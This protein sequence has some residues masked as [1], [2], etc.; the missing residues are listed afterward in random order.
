MGI[1]TSTA[2]KDARVLGNDIKR[3]LDGIDPTSLNSKLRGLVKSLTAAQYGMEKCADAANKIANTK[4]PTEDY[5]YVSKELDKAE[6]SLARMIEKQASMERDGD[7]MGRS[8]QTLSAEIERTQKNISGLKDELR[9]METANEAFVSGRTTEAFQKNLKSLNLQNQL[10]AIAIERFKEYAEANGIVINTTQQETEAT[11]QETEA[12]KN[13]QKAEEELDNSRRKRGVSRGPALHRGISRGPA[14]NPIEQGVVRGPAIQGATFLKEGQDVRRLSREEENLDNSVKKTNVDLEQQNKSL[15]NT[16]RGFNNA[17]RAARSF[18]STLL[19]SIGKAIRRVIS[20]LGSISRH[21]HSSHKS[22]RGLG[23]SMKHTFTTFMRY[24]LGIRS[25]FMLVRRLRGYIKE[26]FGVMAQEIPEVNKDISMLGTSFKELKATFGTMLQPLL[27]ALAPILNDL[28]QKVIALMNNIAK[29]FATLTGQNY[30]YQATV[31]NYDYAKSAEEAQKAN[32]GALASFDKLNVIQKDNT[33]NTMALTK[34]T[35]KYKKVKIEPDENNWWVAFGKLLREGWKNINLT[36]AGEWFAEGIA[37]LLDAIP[38]DRIQEKGKN[39]GKLA[40]TFINGITNPDDLKGKSHLAVAIGGFFANLIQL[41]VNSLSSFVHTI[42]WSNLGK[43]IA[44][45]IDTLKTQLRETDAWKTAGEAFGRLFQGLV[46]FG[47]ELVVKGNIFSGLGTDLFTMFSAAL[48]KGLE[49]NPETGNTYLKDFGIMITNALT[50]FLDEV[51]D[52]L[53]KVDKDGKLYDAIN[54][55][56]LG[57][58]LIEI[59]KRMVKVFLKGFKIGLKALVE[60][61][62][63]A[64][65]ISVDADTAEFFAEAIGIGILGSKIAGLVRNITGSGGLLSAFTKKD[66]SLETQ[67]RKVESESAAVGILSGILGLLGLTAGHTSDEIDDLT[68]KVY[69]MGLVA[70]ED[71]DPALV[72]IRDRI[73]DIGDAGQAVCKQVEDDAKASVNDISLTF[74][75][76]VIKLNEVD[77]SAYN[78]VISIS[79][80]VINTLEQMWAGAQLIAHVQY[81]TP[82]GAIDYGHTPTSSEQALIGQKGNATAL[83]TVGVGAGLTSVVKADSLAETLR[84]IVS[85]DKL[86]T[87]SGAPYSQLI[88]N[89]INATSQSNDAIL[90]ANAQDLWN[91]IN[92]VSDEK[93][94]EAL[95]GVFLDAGKSMG[96]N[97]LEE[98]LASPGAYAGTWGLILANSDGWESIVKAA[99]HGDLN[100]L[101][102]PFSQREV[103]AEDFFRAF[104]KTSSW[105]NLLMGGSYSSLSLPVIGGAFAKGVVIPPNKPSLGILGDQTNGTNVE[106]P[107]STIKQAVAEVLSSIQIKNTFDVKGDPN[108]IFKVVVDESK[109]YYNQHG[110]S[111]F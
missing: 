27:H 93:I 41:G 26:A 19:N 95:M 50:K 57:I 66:R 3:I 106:T 75:Q 71:A 40:A 107:L 5:A 65:G 29:F 63:G 56:F 73:Y 97:K 69:A 110:Y 99:V 35:V 84:G 76:A 38:W 91:Q 20:G 34:D 61:A 86:S 62:A 103:D 22:S 77:T 55:L 16:S 87:V 12:T 4:I 105:L 83:S 47:L 67:R 68:Q 39:G 6:K 10:A 44:D 51:I 96:Y 31:A 46:E 79:K 14:I 1:D 43:F 52:F 104:K 11:K 48:E 64:L 90:K 37:G 101:K 36:E 21:L 89:S 111:A 102:M 15:G 98:I 60:G 58:D 85:A 109:I 59:A 74:G 78:S 23:D 49:V 25:I 18:A 82:D 100:G 33:K 80:Q 108:A 54:Q 94:Q 70:E 92:V 17:N 42:D 28:I 24:T 30:V 8:Y 9:D 53:D 7:T 13:L 32:E 45:S 88:A 81:K 2:L 72:A